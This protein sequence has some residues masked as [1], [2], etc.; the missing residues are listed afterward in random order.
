[1]AKNNNYIGYHIVA[2]ILK[3]AGLIWFGGK[4]YGKSNIPKNGSCILAGNH[5]SDFDAYLLFASTNRPIHFLGKKE[6]FDGKMA[7]FFK[8]M[9]LIPV[10]RKN[11]NPE[12][13]E[14]SLEILKEGKVIGIFPEGTYH[15]EDLLLPFK[16]GVIN[17]AE[18]SG[19]PIIPF[20]MDSTFKFR[21]KPVIKFGNPIYIDKIKEKDKVT[22]LENVVRD[23]LIELKKEKQDLKK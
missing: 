18:K 7:W 4:I 14:K 8:M 9:H 20:A 6:L 19:A 5:L 11:K 22:Y 23:M 16:P 10:D 2:K 17:F 21:C 13:R 12:A 3:F 15:K 1:M